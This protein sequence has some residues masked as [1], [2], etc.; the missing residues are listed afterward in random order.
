MSYSSPRPGPGKALRRTAVTPP[1]GSTACLEGR[2]R[3]VRSGDHDKRDGHRRR[4]HIVAG[5]QLRSGRVILV[6]C[7]Y[8]DLSSE[9]QWPHRVALIGIVDRQCGH[10]LVVGTAAGASSFFLRAFMP[11][12]RKKMAKATMRK[13][14][15]VLISSP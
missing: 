2:I 12:I 9:V 8:A 4:I 1:G 10:S 3:S 11:R 15:M 5:G 13:L 6:P 14:T 7:P